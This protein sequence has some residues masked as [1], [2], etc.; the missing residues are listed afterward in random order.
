MSQIIINVEAQKS[1]PQDYDILNRAIFYVSRLV[2]SQK[3]R[4]FVN[5]SYDDIK[6]VYSIWVCMDMEEN[7][8]NHIHLT[9][10]TL[11]GHHHWKGKLDLLNIVMIGLAKDLPPHDDQ[12]E[13]H[14][15][16]GAL[17]S[18]ELTVDEKL[19]IMDTEYQIPVEE[20]FREDVSVMC[21]LSQGIKED[22]IKIGEEIGEERGI[23]IGEERG[24]GIGEANII[25][26]MYHNG[27]TPQQIAAATDK[28]LKEI[29]SILENR[30]PV[31]E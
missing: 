23:K 25:I 1:D 10:D 6:R 14:R 17:L 7:S 2:S 19:N 4:D 9:N 28:K 27:F 29:E 20:D 24:K 12:H 21:N 15:L 5:S 26:T 22:G 8:L 31:T 3:E 30:E 11:L 18:K 16:L 13:L